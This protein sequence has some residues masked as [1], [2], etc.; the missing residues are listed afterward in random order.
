MSVFTDPVAWVQISNLYG[1]QEELYWTY[2]KV[3]AMQSII[4]FGAP[5]AINGTRFS[6]ASDRINEQRDIVFDF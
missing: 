5:I 2:G 6:S 1:N 3:T 4:N